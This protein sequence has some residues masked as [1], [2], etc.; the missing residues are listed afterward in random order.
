MDSGLFVETQVIIRIG[1]GKA[2]KVRSADR[3]E[4][5]R[6]GMVSD[7]LVQTG[8]DVHGPAAAA[9]MVRLFH[10]E[11]YP[12]QKRIPLLDGGSFHHFGI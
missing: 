5:Q 11:K 3:G 4:E 2:I 7:L 12:K 1:R 9:V 6:V 8:V 10:T